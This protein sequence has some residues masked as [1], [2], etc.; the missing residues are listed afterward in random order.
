MSRLRWWR[1][2][3]EIPVVELRRS[4]PIRVGIV[5]LVIL[6]IAVYFGFTKR[7]PFK[8]GFR[9]KAVF[10]TAVNIHPSSPVRIAGVNVGK[11]TSIQREGNAGLVNMEIEPKG[12]PIHTDAT[13]K[14]RPRIFLEG[15]WFVDMQPGSPT[16][17]TISSGYTIPLT[18]TADPVQ[19]DQVLN[20]LNTDT[21]ANLQDFLQGYGD[22]LTRKPDAAEN[23]EQDPDV[24][25]LNAAQALNKT[26]HRAP[27]ALRDSAIVNQAL[28][29]T[30]AHDLSQLIVAVG[31]VTGALNMHEQQLGEFA[32]NFNAFLASFAAESP[33]LR[34]AVAHLPG[35]LTNADRAFT[36]LNASFGPTRAFLK[37]ILPGIQQQGPTIAAALPWIEQVQASLAP[38]ELGGVA[39]GLNEA[40]PTLAQLIGEQ[41][42]FFKQTDEFSKCLTKLFFPGANTKLQDGASTSGVEVYKEFWSSLTGLAGFGQGFSGNGTMAHALIGNSGQVVRSGHTSILGTKLQGQQ[43]LAHSPLQPLGTRP[44]YP[45]EEPPY[46]PLVA[47]YTQTPFDFNGPLS[48]GPADGSG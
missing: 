27:S 38:S 45:A 28:G 15:N 20:A 5:F 25:G 42:P 7:I 30:E 46:R 9:L 33:S 26:Y 3:D 14:I 32:P 44:A 35:A 43:L 41:V 37:A 12:L 13:L 29:G 34:A 11:V 22:G 31:K 40:A 17:K 8:H 23:A 16:A 6:L 10:T 39:R 48:Q 2:H 1:R 36:A 19:L 18:Q 21:R 47:C 4:N 24:H